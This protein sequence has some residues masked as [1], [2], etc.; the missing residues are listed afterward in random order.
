[1]PKINLAF[2]HLWVQRIESRRGVVQ[3]VERRYTQLAEALICPVLRQ[4][5][6]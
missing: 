3:P 1:V 6:I 2:L 5:L 4:S